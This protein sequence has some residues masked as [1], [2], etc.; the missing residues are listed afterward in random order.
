M[1]AFC[2]ALFLTLLPAPPT[3]EVVRID[4]SRVLAGDTDIRA[5]RLEYASAVNAGDA[6]R[7]SEL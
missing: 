2:A 7:A 1:Q 3:Q 4:W 5:L 6:G